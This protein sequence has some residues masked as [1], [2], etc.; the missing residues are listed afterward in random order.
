MKMIL[1]FAQTSKN[2]WFQKVL[3]IYEE[4]IGRTI[5]FDIK[6]IKS[7]SFSRKDW[8]KKVAVE[9]ERLLKQIS[10]QDSVLVFDKGGR[11]FSDSRQFSSYLVKKLELGYRRL[12]FVIGGAY[13]LGPRL[14]ERADDLISLSGLTMNQQV[15]TVVA[16][17]QIYRALTLW[18]GLPYHND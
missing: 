2:D 16:L 9:D 17:E 8:G 6:A 15:A 12:I 3:V 1:I 10:D 13:G 18:K 11:S 7:D 5:P 4:K 14:R